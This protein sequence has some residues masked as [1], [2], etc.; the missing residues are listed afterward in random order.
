MMRL[1]VRFVFLNHDS[2]RTEAG[3]RSS[4]KVAAQ[5]P[6][7]KTR[8]LTLLVWRIGVVAIAVVVVLRRFGAFRDTLA[9][10]LERGLV[11]VVFKIPL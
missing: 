8:D 5:P 4:G 6:S 7:P 11:V 3:A 2:R 1:A 9:E 10:L